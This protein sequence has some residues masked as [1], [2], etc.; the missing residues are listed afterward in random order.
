MRR[1]VYFAGNDTFK[2][3]V[4]P[5][6]RG[7]GLEETTR[8]KDADILYVT[9]GGHY[10]PLAHPISWYGKQ[11][12]VFHWIGSDVLR[13]QE[14]IRSKNIIKRLYY[15]LWRRLMLRKHRRK[16]LISLA[17]TEH[18]QDKLSSIG[19][20]AEVFPITSIHE[21]TIRM[22]E[23]MDAGSAAKEARQGDAEAGKREAKTG[24]GEA[25]RSKTG[26][27]DRHAA[28]SSGEAYRATD[29]IGYI[30]MDDFD[31]YG[32]PLFAS[33]AER[34][35]QRRF[36]VV[37]P[38]RR[39]V[40]DEERAQFPGNVR[41]LPELSFEAMQQELASSRCMFRATRHD[42][43]SLLVLE[44]LLHEIHVLWSQPFPHT[45]HVDPE[46]TAP[47]EL[48]ARVEHLIAMKEKNT[49]GKR[50]VIERYRTDRLQREF[51]KLFS[52]F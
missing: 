12:M 43:L 26:K 52:G 38:D 50:F 8:K 51:E 10:G 20:P 18:L 7:A 36:T 41:V 3:H 32:G 22:A 1:S 37:V 44:A 21:D 25:E 27:K 15:R 33:L 40:S 24:K 23:E 31:F 17:V 49:E 6:F 19:I 29:V 4:I 13:W 45:Y 16:Q 48:A 35:P 47:E 11:N 14:G 34:L 42:G 9:F 39:K 46:L 2:Q 5:F 30:P 28:A